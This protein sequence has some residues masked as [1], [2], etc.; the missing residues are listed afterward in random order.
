MHYSRLA[1]M[2]GIVALVKGVNSLWHA[3]AICGETSSFSGLFPPGNP[4]Q[5]DFESSSKI[6]EKRG[7]I[8]RGRCLT[9]KICVCL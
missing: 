1:G 2:A 5:E 8:Y 6:A 3:F 7:A 9:D 4:D